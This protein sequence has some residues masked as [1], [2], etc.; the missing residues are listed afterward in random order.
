MTPT[1]KK[2]AKHPR[3]Y[4]FA[5]VIIAMLCAVLLW[6]YVLGY[7]SPDFE[8]KFSQISVTV[9]GN[10][11]LTERTGYTVISDMTFSFDVTVAGKKTDVNS[12]RET[13]ITAYVDV[14]NVNSEGGIYLPVNVIVPNGITVKSQSVSQAYL[15]IDEMV[16]AEVPVRVEVSD[17]KLPENTVIGD[18][19]VNPVTVTV[20]GPRT[21]IEKISEAYA[22]VTP[23]DITG[24]VTLNTSVV[25]R[26]KDG[27]EIHPSAYL[28]QIDRS[29]S[30]TLPVYT[31]KLLPVKVQ[32]IGGVFGVD[33]AVITL[34]AND[35]LVR[36]TA[37]ALA[38]IDEV[39]LNIDETTLDT[40]STIIK[41]VILPDGVENVS[42]I[43]TIEVGIQLNQ[44]G[45]RTVAA[46]KSV[47]EL[48]NVPEG[49]D[50]QIITQSLNIDFVGPIDLM[51]YFSSKY[52]TVVIDLSG[53]A[54]ESGD[55]FFVPVTVIFKSEQPGVYVRGDY[56]VNIIV[57]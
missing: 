34:S 40:Y 10:D 22:N 31:T 33:N 7:D 49:A 57:N 25:L 12:M 4:N 13:D 35:I 50:V 39:A 30:V 17:Y 56:S 20:Q 51:R 6:L 3:L 43:D 5:V 23:G 41:R 38:A 55:N 27:A 48:R 8:K 42:G 26:G 2:K 16:T 19:T 44:M 28:R 54:V 37:S 9:V 15:F 46:D 32:F 45:R 1:N 24:S 14:S 47:F 21:D 18:Y 29:V 52:F 36:G 11:E 53:L